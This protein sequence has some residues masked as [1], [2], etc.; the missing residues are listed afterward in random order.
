MTGPAT[1]GLCGRDN[2]PGHHAWS[3]PVYP[4]PNGDRS[5]SH[6]QLAWLCDGCRTLEETP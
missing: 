1:C 2:Q 4:V 5:V 3:A 6:G